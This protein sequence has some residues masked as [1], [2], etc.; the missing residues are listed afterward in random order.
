MR[1]RHRDGTL[2]HLSYCTNVHPAVDL[3]GVR[4]QLVRFAAP[5]RERLGAPVL[6]VGLWLAAPVAAR[7]AADTGERRDLR[8]LLDRLGLEVVTLNGFPHDDFGTGRVKKRVY[9]PDWVHVDRLRY[10]QDLAVV[11]ADLLPDDAAGGSISTL[12]LAWREPW[13][14]EQQRAAEAQLDRLARFLDRLDEDTGRRV[15]VA[16]EPEPGC[17]VET[18]AQAVD[19]LASVDRA[20]VGVCV[21]TAHLAVAWEEPDEA[22]GRLQGAGLDVVKAQLSAALHVEHPGD[23]GTLEVLRRFDEDRYLHQVRPGSGPGSGW[24]TGWDDLGEAFAH[25]DG[26]PWRVHFHLP[27]GAE[28]AAPLASTRATLRGS[29]RALV[30]GDRALTDHLDVETYTW[31]VLPDPPGS[32]DE[33][34]AGLA[35]ELAWARDELVLAGLEEAT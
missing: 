31:T 23:A 16:V 29:L 15:R 35:A 7:L 3:D 9:E 20:R 21:D 25:A 34:V 8:D 17:V 28:P 4:A 27:L 2:V 1:F 18:T 22:V 5:V 11:L 32:D 13:S 24:S 12:P 30:G 6:G 10:T 33:L 19:R 14:A 26:A